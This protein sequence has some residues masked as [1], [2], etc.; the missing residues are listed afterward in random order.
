MI[1]PKS[2]NKCGDTQLF[3]Q[4]M[5]NWLYT[6]I[7]TQIWSMLNM[8]I[9]RE[10]EYKGLRSN[11]I[12]TCQDQDSGMSQTYHV[13]Y[14]V[15][16]L[17]SMYVL[18]PCLLNYGPRICQKLGCEVL[19]HSVCGQKGIIIQYISSTIYTVC[20]MRNR[21][22]PNAITNATHLCSGPLVT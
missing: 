22:W 3:Q 10:G 1:S 5:P 12:E 15:Q 13:Q 9:I 7:P 21:W 8:R 16:D 2:I 19:E 20:T 14:R 17:A 4:W 11:C 18:H 6:V